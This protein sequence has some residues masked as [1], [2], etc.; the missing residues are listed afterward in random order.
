MTAIDVGPS[1]V[2]RANT[3]G[4]SYL[5]VEYA[6][7]VGLDG[8][9][10]TVNYW[11]SGACTEL[12]VGIFEHLGN[13]A[14]RCRSLNNLGAHGAGYHEAEAVTLNAKVGD[15]IGFY[16]VGG[17]ME[18]STSGGAGEWRCNNLVP[19]EELYFAATWDAGYECSISG[20][21]ATEELTSYAQDVYDDLDDTYNNYLAGARAWIRANYDWEPGD[22]VLA[23]ISKDI[24]NGGGGGGGGI[25]LAQL[26][27]E[28]DTRFGATA[29]ELAQKLVDILYDIGVSEAPNTG[30]MAALT[31][32]DSTVAG[33]ITDAAQDVIDA[34]N[35][36]SMADVPTV[37]EIAA[38]V[39]A[40][41]PTNV[42]DAITTISGEIDDAVASIKGAGSP[43][44]A[45]VI[46]E[47]GDIPTVD[48][49]GV[50]SAVS[51]VV[52]TL[53]GDLTA[54]E[55]DVLDAIAGLD[56]GAGWPG[57]AGAT[58]DSPVA[59][60]N[61]LV[62]NTA[63]DG[64]LVNITTPPTRTGVYSVG[65]TYY[66]YKEGLVAFESDNGYMEMWQYLGF[67]QA[68]YTPKSMERAAKVHFQVLAGAEGNV[69]TWRRA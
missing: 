19:S 54:L 60:S 12:Y 18:T 57:L 49:S 30:L 58:L 66:D 26:Q 1:V 28:L 40:A 14:L 4:A 7:P 55:S 44:L 34:V 15:Y 5:I 3:R 46:T 29:V 50:L 36:L 47:I 22:M 43:D 17:S 10:T 51:G 61:G 6:N 63:C 21:G 39:G 41:T 68:L 9:I 48:L 11:L 45:A 20:D 69:I 16:L 35:A 62:I 31:T 27:G 25:T 32:H 65:D 37:E 13:N 33:E 24:L 53:E 64:V 56:F 38:A 23:A 42:S 59:L 67:R 2:D 8:V 52:T